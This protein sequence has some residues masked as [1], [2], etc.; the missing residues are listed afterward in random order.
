[1]NCGG[2]AGKRK[3]SAEAEAINLKSKG[4]RVANTQS[5]IPGCNLSL[6]KANRDV[7]QASIEVQLSISQEKEKKQE[8]AS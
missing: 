4:E 1:M 3:Y 6:L 5:E 2:R 7:V 8:K